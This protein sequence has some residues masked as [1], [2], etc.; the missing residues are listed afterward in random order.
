[1]SSQKLRMLYLKRVRFK[2]GKKKVASPTLEDLF[3]SIAKKSSSWIDRHY[4]LPANVKA[5][6]RC[7][8]VGE[9]QLRPKSPDG[10]GGGYY[11]TVGSYVHGKGE[12]QIALV[13]S[14]TKPTVESGPLMGTDG[15]QRALLHEFRCVALGETLI[16]QNEQGGGGSAALAMLLTNLFR[17]YHNADLPSIEL[18][19]VFSKDLRQ[20]IESEGGAERM[21]IRMV[22]AMPADADPEKTYGGLLTEVKDRVAGAGTFTGEWCAEDGDLDIDSVID[23]YNES[24]DGFLNQVSIKTVDGGWI[25]ALGRYRAAREIHVTVDAHGLEH[26]SEIMPSLFEYLDDIRKFE[27]GNWRL[28]ND[29]GMFTTAAMLKVSKKKG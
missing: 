21:R 6:D 3:A 1:M 17:R 28:V 24:D 9:I 22:G 26:T 14:G 18:V 27:G 7:T 8:Y 20:I 5:G 13:L 12:H 16:I 10:S 15:K 23:A 29:D 25:K 19:D 2:W 11:F 4:P